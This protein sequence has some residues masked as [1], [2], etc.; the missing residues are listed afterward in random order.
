MIKITVKDEFGTK[1]YV[2]FVVSE[3]D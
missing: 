3:A 2:A 1:D